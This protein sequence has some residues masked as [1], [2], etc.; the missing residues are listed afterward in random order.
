MAGAD[1]ATTD[2][3]TAVTID[4]LTNDSDVDTDDEL[5]AE[6]DSRDD[7]SISL[8]GVTTTP[9]HGDVAVVDGKIVYTPDTNWYGKD[10]FTYFI[11]GRA[12]R[13]C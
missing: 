13:Q 1:S 12:R 10:T 7:F 2:E 8:T 5:N 6:P 3:D 9:S 4:V 11:S